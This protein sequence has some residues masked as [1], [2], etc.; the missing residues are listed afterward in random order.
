MSLIAHVRAQMRA[1]FSPCLPPKLVSKYD[2]W[3]GLSKNKP[4]RWVEIIREVA[5]QY[6]VTADA[7]M[8]QRRCKPI[9]RARQACMWRFREELNYSY[10]MISRRLNR[11]D[12]TTSI[13]GCRQH[14]KRALL[15]TPSTPTPPLPVLA[16]E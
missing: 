13:H 3:R 2:G 6:G 10:P 8:S 16:A 12:H 14:E 5:D 9:S 4:G 7:I 1:D 11:K 15:S